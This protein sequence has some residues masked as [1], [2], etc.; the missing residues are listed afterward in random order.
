MGPRMQV[1][2]P[3]FSAH[4]SGGPSVPIQLVVINQTSQMNLTRLWHTQS[5]PNPEENYYPGKNGKASHAEVRSLF[6]SALA[7]PLSGCPCGLGLI[8][9]LP[10]NTGFL[11]HLKYKTLTRE[12]A[13][14]S[15]G[16]QKQRAH[17]NVQRAPTERS[18]HPGPEAA[19]P[20]SSRVPRELGL[21]GLLLSCHQH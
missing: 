2:A 5:R 4:H 21:A 15:L 14:G 16:Y 13:K 20:K 7:I 18:C 19:E 17:K 10:P 6:L 1:P 12:A 11:R 3:E 8:T 9:L